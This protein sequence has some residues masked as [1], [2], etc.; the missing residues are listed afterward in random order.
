VLTAPAALLLALWTF[1]AI[2]FDGPLPGRGNLALGSAWLAVVA[3]ALWR[4]R[5]GLRKAL[6][7][8]A[9][10]CLVWI[11]WLALPASKER[12]W[13]PEVAR[14]ARAVVEGDVVTLHDVR[15]FD[16]RE[17]GEATE[18]WETRRLR[19]SELRGIDL[20]LT[21]WGSPWIAHP[22]VSFDF[23]PD[24]RV[25]FSIE[26]R[27]ERG[28]SYSAVAGFFKQFELIYVV[29][30]ER[31]V[32][33][34]RTNHREGEDVYLY[35]FVVAPERARGRFLE[36]V[37][38]VNELHERPEWY[39]ALTDNCTTSIRAQRA[40]SDRAPFDWRL[41]LN[42]KID[43]WLH[44]LGALRGG[45]PF[46][47]LKQRAHINPQ[48]RAADRDADFSERIRAGVPGFQRS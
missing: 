34:L 8:L 1:G 42:G 3:A 27:P 24:G 46:P 6:A 26:T 30:D 18:R 47:E 36:Y 37:A 33:R 5:P 21:H 9:L 43:E 48:A 41:I 32:V 4:V 2:R 44:E 19:L 11:P 31:D 12:D 28:E 16:W 13:K 22:I 17:G 15:D 45:L 10:G 39:N 40:A 23:G 25:A 7:V 20:F 29:A 14:T 35:G 38:R